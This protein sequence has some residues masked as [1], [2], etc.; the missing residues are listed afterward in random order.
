MN[1]IGSKV[2]SL[3]FDRSVAEKMEQRILELHNLG[4]QGVGNLIK[5]LNRA[6]DLDTFRD[7]W[8]EGTYSL[9]FAANNSS[10]TM[11]PCGEKGPD[12]LININGHDVYVEVKHLRVNEQT[13]LSARAVAGAIRHKLKQTIDNEIN[14]FIMDS[15][16]IMGSDRIISKTSFYRGIYL[17]RDLCRTDSLSASK[18][19]NLNC[20]I[21]HMPFFDFRSHEPFYW[22][23]LRSA[24]KKVPRKV[25]R[26][27]KEI[28]KGQTAIER[29]KIIRMIT[30]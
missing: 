30:D 15:D 12:M 25:R 26:G 22:R 10:V 16:R 3:G 7:Y 5:K 24:T 8:I 1:S 20:V 13:K 17:C 27:V 23:F 4:I 18:L 11:E 28:L 19:P 2:R 9:V 29:Q 6:P 21:I 14:I